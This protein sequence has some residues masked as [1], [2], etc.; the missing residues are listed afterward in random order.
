M[1]VAFIWSLVELKG[2]SQQSVVGFLT[3][4]EALRY[5]KVS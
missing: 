3:I 1:I 5:C 4:L 2:I